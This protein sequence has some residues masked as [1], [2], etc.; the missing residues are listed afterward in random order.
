MNICKVEGFATAYPLLSGHIK[1]VSHPLCNICRRSNGRA[2]AGALGQRQSETWDR[3]FELKPVCF[4]SLHTILLFT[5]NSPPHHTSSWVYPGLKLHTVTGC[6]YGVVSYK[7]SHALR[8]FS[9]IVW[10]PICV[11]IILDSTT[12]A[13]WRIPKQ[14]PSM[15]A[16]RNLARHLR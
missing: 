2:T 14:T 3:G 10:V 5:I 1:W 8:P 15:E 16:G 12:R 6:C 9:D 13:L 11:L 7:A 4:S